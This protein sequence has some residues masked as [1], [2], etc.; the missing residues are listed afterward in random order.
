LPPQ[1]RQNKSLWARRDPGLIEM[2][3]DPVEEAEDIFAEEE[4]DLTII[5]KASEVV[6]MVV[7]RSIIL[8]L[9]VQMRLLLLV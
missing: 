3:Q 1:L 4:A 8:W 7:V 5:T 2:N 9:F 6:V